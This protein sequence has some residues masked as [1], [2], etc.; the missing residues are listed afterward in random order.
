MGNKKSTLGKVPKKLDSSSSIPPD[1]PLG[2][3]LL[4]WAENPRAKDKKKQKND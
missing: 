3:M 2:F 1:S 4:Y